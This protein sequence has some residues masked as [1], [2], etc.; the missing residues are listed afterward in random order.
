[1]KTY[2]VYIITN[3]SRSVLY[4]G[5]TNNLER[6]LFEHK[7]GIVDGFTKKYKCKYLLYFEETTDVQSAIAR[8]KQI[9][10]WNRAKKDALNDTLN[11][12]REDLS[13]SVEMTLGKGL[14][15]RPKQSEVEKSPKKNKG[16]L[17]ASSLAKTM[18]D[19]LVEMTRTDE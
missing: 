14:S 10:Q 4:V 1:M 19:K 3:A 2:Y 13:A 6:R 8:E 11:P 15:F 9:K 7:T 5:V 17:S 18:E 12:N 16:D